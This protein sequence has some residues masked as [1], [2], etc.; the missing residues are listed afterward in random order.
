MQALFCGRP[1]LSQPLSGGYLRAGTD[2][3]AFDDPDDLLQQVTAALASDRQPAA[4]DR[5]AFTVEALT[6][7]LGL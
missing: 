2:Y 7:R 6:R 4:I 1:V 3:I 5:S